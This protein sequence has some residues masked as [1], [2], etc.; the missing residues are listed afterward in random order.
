MCTSYHVFP[1]E[2][3]EMREI[4][5]QAVRRF[6]DY[7]PKAGRISPS[8][9]TLV[10]DSE[11]PGVMRFGIP[12]TGKKGLLLNARSEGTSFSPLFSPMLRAQRCLV[13][14]SSF[15]E[16]DADKKAFLFSSEKGGTL[17]FA[18]LYT[19]AAPLH[20]FVIITRAAD[21]AVSPI[22]DRMPLI[23]PSPE[24]QEAWLRSPELAKDLLHIKPD[25]PLIRVSA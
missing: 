12:L 1:E 15:Y 9:A 25:L 2:N 13:P 7:P 18:G 10:I 16:W 8:E 24:Y 22:H 20:Q 11:G 17:Y 4:I 19:Y 6:P 14:A 21:Q 5:S 23:L 3:T